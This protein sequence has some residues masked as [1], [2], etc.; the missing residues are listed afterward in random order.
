[1]TDKQPN[2]DDWIGSWIAQQRQL[3]QAQAAAGRA[4][5]LDDL[6]RRWLDLGEAYLKGLAHHSEGADKGAA[7]G[8]AAAQFKVGDD[9]LAAWRNAW[10]GADEGQAGLGRRFAELMEVMPF[11]GLAREQTQAW[12]E[13]SAA[14]AECRRL[15]QELADVLSRVQ[16]DALSLLEQR[17]RERER[18]GQPVGNFRALYDLWV[19]CGEH[20]Y[21]QVAHSDAYSKLQAELGNATMRLKSRQQ[22]LLEHAL[23]QF[24]LPTRTELN[25]VHRQVREL[26]A[27]LAALEAASQAATPARRASK[28]RS[29][30]AKR[31]PAQARRKRK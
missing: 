18:A 14:Q 28:P 25:T 5:S 7:S 6:G 11:L 15:G 3:L 13:L 17:V 22:T 30:A 19:E 2:A 26:R 9:I 12:R 20:V 29:S 10:A 24:D 1:M 21:A 31:A 27:Q 16:S 8:P 4:A 23:K